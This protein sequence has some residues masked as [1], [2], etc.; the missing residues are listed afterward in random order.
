[1]KHPCKAYIIS[2]VPVDSDTFT[3]TIQVKDAEGVNV[4]TTRDIVARRGL[5]GK[6]G[7]SVA[8][9]MIYNL[10]DVYEIKR[11]L[12][13]Q[14]VKRLLDVHLGK[15]IP[16]EG[17]IVGLWEPAELEIFAR[18][19]ARYNIEKLTIKPIQEQDD[20]EKD[21]YAIAGN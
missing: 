11:K 7:V 16:E 8:N 2:A 13:E 17:E 4:G 19:I 9:F 20:E 12:V 15:Y 5:P 14:S 1:M 3:V 18:R 6:E 10:V 21:E